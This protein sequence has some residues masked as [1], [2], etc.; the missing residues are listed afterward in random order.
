MAANPGCTRLFRRPSWSGLSS[1]YF[2]VAG[3]V[4]YQRHR[5][6]NVTAQLESDCQIF[7]LRKR[8][9]RRKHGLCSQLDRSEVHENRACFVELEVVVEIDRPLPEGIGPV[10]PPRG[11]IHARGRLP[12]QFHKRGPR[13][14][15]IPAG[16][17]FTAPDAAVPRRQVDDNSFNNVI[18]DSSVT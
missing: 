18:A 11:V 1:S 12:V 14:A 6:G 8:C 13:L 9:S 7:S 10:L 17:R 3:A 4:R 2:V 15:S 5:S 16:R